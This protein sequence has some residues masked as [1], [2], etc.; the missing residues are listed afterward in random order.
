MVYE[1]NFRNGSSAVPLI[2]NAEIDRLL[3][4]LSP[5]ERVQWCK[6]SPFSPPCQ[7]SNFLSVTAVR[8]GNGGSDATLRDGE[9]FECLFMGRGLL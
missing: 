3:I 1:A 7:K 4:K 9:E 2:L 6:M 8:T 5:V